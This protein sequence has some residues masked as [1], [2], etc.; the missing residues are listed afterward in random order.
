MSHLIDMERLRDIAEVEGSFRFCWTI[1][2]VALK[3][4]KNWVFV[5]ITDLFRVVTGLWMGMVQLHPANS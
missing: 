1:P 5:R 3:V 4:A 2:Y